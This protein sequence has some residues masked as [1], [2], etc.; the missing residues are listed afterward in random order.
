MS[1]GR[2]AA[3]DVGTNSVRLLVVESDGSRLARELA[4]TRL[5]QG[6]DETG[7]LDDDA[8]SRTLEVMARYRRQWEELGAE[9]VRIA[10]TS[11]VRDAA[12]RDRFLSGVR[13]VAG[14][15]PEILSGEEEALIAF[16]G[17]T[18]ALDVPRPT[19]V[20]DVGGGSTE[21]IVGDADGDYAASVSLQLGC[22]RLTE[23][24][25]P[26]D[27]PT[28]TELADARAEMAAQLDRGAATLAEHGADPEGCAT[29][30]GVAGT[31]TT[32]AALHLGLDHYDHERVHGTC[33]PR[34]ALQR[35]AR[36]LGSLPAAE[37]KQLGPVTPGRED[38]IFGGALIVQ[39][40]LERFGFSELIASEADSLDG[41]VLGRTE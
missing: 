13:E 15:E 37:R 11:A 10:A 27:P 20:L 9:D 31:V 4:V 25:L 6:V 34:E 35:L 17:A 16:R 33:L 38:V 7:H 32:L 41:L 2:R 14:R 39:G 12:D 3:V 19:A 26:S 21:L 18:T 22:V 23:R 40:V 28:A 24:L 5:G 36:Q 30:V 1:K 8:L 29:L